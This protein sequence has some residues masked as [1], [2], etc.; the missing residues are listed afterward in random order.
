LRAAE[1]YGLKSKIKLENQTVARGLISDASIFNI[2][3]LGN[4]VISSDYEI[5]I[6]NELD[7]QKLFDSFIRQNL[8][9]FHPED[10]SIGRLKESIY[11]FLLL[12]LAWN[13]QV[14]KA[15]S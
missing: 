15:K 9:P 5:A 2:D 14:T 4:T 1:S 8:E 6:R 10:R 7:L 11:G 13:T 3:E 12:V